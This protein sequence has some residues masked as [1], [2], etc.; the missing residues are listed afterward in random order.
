MFKQ[1]AIHSLIL[2]ISAYFNVYLRELKA[3]VPRVDVYQ[4][5]CIV[6]FDSGVNRSSVKRL[7]WQQKPR[8]LKI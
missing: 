3:D 6:A 4:D 8:N 1:S 7:V 5:G 2:I